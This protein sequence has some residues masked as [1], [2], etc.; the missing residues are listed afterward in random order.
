MKGRGTSSHLPGRYEVHTVAREDDGWAQP[1][2]LPDEPPRIAT[3][4][5]VETARSIISRNQSPDIPFDQSINTYR[6]C[7]HGCVYCYAR[8]SH[9]YLNLSPGLDFET[10]L[11]AKTNAAT[12]LRQELAK[13]GYVPSPINLGANTDPFQPIED[14]WQ[15]THQ[16][17]EVLLECRH[18]LTIVTKNGRVDRELP[19]LTEL[20][21]LDLV[22]VFVSIT[23]LDNRLSATLEP[24]A[25]APHR[26]IAALAK[27]SEA[28]V[29][30]SVLVAP[31]IPAITDAHLERVLEAS[32]A[33]GARTAGYTL[34]RLP[35]EVKPLFE[36]WL[37]EHFPQRAEHVMSL[38]RQMRDGRA[39]DPEFGSRMKG[40]GV[41]AE[42]IRTRFRKAVARLGF[43]ARADIQ[44]SQ[45]L[46]RRPQVVPAKA[47][48]G[49]Q[50]QQQLSLF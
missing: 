24:R 44:L 29:P 43:A 34:I 20:A 2:Q 14:D 25:S 49:Q 9:A 50:L 28:G 12:L 3:T 47:P 46:F 31:V 21:K 7:E 4:V 26:R 40:T 16:V 8:P 45:A 22:H 48:D 13:P 32:R 27:L 37:A 39:N 38:V 36:A 6:G 41:F 19:I 15:L 5:A 30:A 33:A 1:G 35:W 11:S 42:L 18:P 23:S 10:R 17:L